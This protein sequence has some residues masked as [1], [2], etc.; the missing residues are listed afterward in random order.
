MDLKH[1]QTKVEQDNRQYA[2]FCHDRILV[3]TNT[4]L[5]KMKYILYINGYLVLM[6][7]QWY[8]VSTNKYKDAVVGIQWRERNNII[9]EHRLNIPWNILW[10]ETRRDEAH[11]EGRVS[12][13]FSLEPSFSFMKS[14]NSSIKNNKRFSS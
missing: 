13:I 5:K 6:P 14:K 4:L 2:P 3:S 10:S 9:V 7:I 11:S 12:Q 1:E 8:K